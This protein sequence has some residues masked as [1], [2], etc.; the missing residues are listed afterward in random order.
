MPSKPPLDSITGRADLLG[1]AGLGEFERDASLRTLHW[2]EPLGELTGFDAHLGAPSLDAFLARVHLSDEPVVR[3]AYDRLLAGEG[4]YRIDY[5][6]EHP[7]R[8]LRWLREIGQPRVDDGGALVGSCGLVQD[9]SDHRL[10]AQRQREPLEEALVARTVSLAQANEQIDAFKHAR[11]AVLGNVSE[12]ISQSLQG[13]LGTIGVIGANAPGGRV[14][15]AQSATAIDEIASAA[16]RLLTM[17]RELADL[18]RIDEGSLALVQDDFS[19][20]TVLVQ[21]H[22]LTE[23]LAS[24]RGIGLTVDP[25]DAPLWLKGDESRLRQALLRCVDRAL[26]VTRRGTIAIRARLV[27]SDHATLVLR[28]EVQDAGADIAPERI[29]QLFAGLDQ[30]DFTQEDGAVPV[31]LGLALTR[32]LAEC[33]GGKA[34]ASSQPGLGTS[35]WFTARFAVGTAPLPVAALSGEASA[36]EQLRMRKPGARVLLVEDNLINCEV[37]AGL[38]TIAGLRVDV[39]HDG[40]QAVE[41]ASKDTYELILMD[42]QMPRMDGL[43]ATRAIRQLP[44]LAGL[45]VVAMTA[46]AFAEDRRACAQAGMNDFIAKPV[47]PEQLFR[48]LLRWIG[49]PAPVAAPPMALALPAG[50]EP[51]L[52]PIAGVDSTRGL[53]SLGGNRKTYRRLLFTFCSTHTDDARLIA[54]LV[55]RGLSENAARLAHRLRGSAATLG[56]AGVDQAALEI[57]QALHEQR[58]PERVSE[59]LSVLALALSAVIAAIQDALKPG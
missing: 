6:F 58:G 36:E 3:H 19:L 33:M 42:V 8:G 21:V 2:S 44:G 57:E 43:Q 5:R 18:V 20:A 31:S 41:M 7:V 54:D 32:G 12:T 4:A 52:P 47:E 35:V 28:F 46:N 9:I 10:A 40:V 30:V 15:T 22:A 14:S 39:A 25:G 49:R 13:I 27:Q 24:A 59:A 55:S 38:M 11:R 17:T 50:T 51:E 16:S 37:A 29:A 48:T 23:P 56:L 53:A 26:A 34:G 1:F 45:P